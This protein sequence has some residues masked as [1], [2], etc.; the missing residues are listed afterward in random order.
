MGNGKSITDTRFQRARCD[1]SAWMMGERGAPEA[2][3]RP[4]AGIEILRRAIRLPGPEARLRN[5][6]RGAGLHPMGAF[7]LTFNRCEEAPCWID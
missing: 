7:W 2:R 5:R 6:E 1:D 3:D 4:P